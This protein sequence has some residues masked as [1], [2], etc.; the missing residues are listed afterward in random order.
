M[1][2]QPVF[3]AGVDAG[4]WI[5]SVLE[6]LDWRGAVALSRA[7]RAW[8]RA[9][10]HAI[11]QSPLGPPM[12]LRAA[13]AWSTRTQEQL[14]CYMQ[15]LSPHLLVALRLRDVSF[16]CMRTPLCYCTS[17]RYVALSAHGIPPYRVPVEC[18]RSA[19]RLDIG[20]HFALDM[21]HGRAWSR[22]VSAADLHTLCINGQDAPPLARKVAPDDVSPAEFRLD[23]VRAPALRVLSCEDSLNGAYAAY[24]IGLAKHLE[25]MR[26][27]A[28]LTASHASVRGP[29]GGY[30]R[31]V[32][33]GSDRAL[34]VMMSMCQRAA[35]AT[36]GVDTGGR[37]GVWMDMECNVRHVRW[38]GNGMRCYMELCGTPQRGVTTAPLCPDLLSGTSGAL[39]A[40]VSVT[41]LRLRGLA[42][43][44]DEG[45][46]H[47]AIVLQEGWRD[48]WFPEMRV[49]CVGAP[50]YDVVAH[51]GIRDCP[52]V[53][54]HPLLNPTRVDLAFPQLHTLVYTSP[55]WAAALLRA[56]RT[57]LVA[58]VRAASRC[59]PVS[60][61]DVH[62]CGS[63]PATANQT[64]ITEYIM[65][66]RGV[67]TVRVHVHTHAVQLHTLYTAAT[68]P[69]F[70]GESLRTLHLDCDATVPTPC[71]L[72]VATEFGRCQGAVPPTTKCGN[73]L[74]L[75][76]R[77]GG[78]SRRTLFRE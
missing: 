39:G 71:E 55:R 23:A 17:L 1:D 40:F 22:R 48:W 20:P 73:E 43:N 61:A 63:A 46:W 65:H 36:A 31:P 75:T 19:W 5:S 56:G 37:G 66:P 6:F 14:L 16:H 24:Y 28:D 3:G 64:C 77:R 11:R 58:C 7:C 8:D 30:T 50:R 18:V 49:L 32:Y 27:V 13:A 44:G 59:W 53:P 52:A 62:V 38:Q 33:A 78:A 10:R 76:R 34:V 72:R 74:V 47:N 9:V 12:H 15:M 54:T 51:P 26:G 35:L 67:G 68:R 70:M 69:E 60:V 29:N 41:K 57:L 2:Q 42:L 45:Y 25:F 4:V 21:V